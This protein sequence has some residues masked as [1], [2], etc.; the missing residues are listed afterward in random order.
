M[1]IRVSP[2][3]RSAATV[4]AFIGVLGS[5]ACVQGHRAADAGD[6]GFPFGPTTL[7]TRT[8][9]YVQDIKPVLDADC[10]SCHSAREARGEYSVSAYPDVLNKQRIGD[11]RSS[12]VRTCSPG[13][14]MYP[15]LRGDAVTKSTMIFRWLVYYN[16]AERR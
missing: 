8:L 12:L 16:A 9:A 7:E 13:G 4:A 3:W 6:P 11:A 1:G 14:S 10:L 15:Y 5:A 2:W